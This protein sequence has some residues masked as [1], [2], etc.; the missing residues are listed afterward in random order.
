MSAL[1][2]NTTNLLQLAI[3]YAQ[4]RHGVIASN[5][6]NADTPGY[7]AMKLPFENFLKQMIMEKEKA[8]G[9]SKRTQNVKLSYPEPQVDTFATQRLDGN[10]VNPDQQMAKLAHNTIL[11]NGFVQLLNAKF[12]IMDTAIS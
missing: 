2:D 4:K 3:S 9:L 5:I 6:V 1:F 8:S 7:K 12:K 10:S 11:Y